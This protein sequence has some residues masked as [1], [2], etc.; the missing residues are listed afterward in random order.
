MLTQNYLYY[1]FKITEAAFL[2][3][4]GL[5]AL[6]MLIVAVVALSKLQRGT[7]LRTLSAGGSIVLAVILF[8][9]AFSNIVYE[10][11]EH[12][13]TLI[14]DLLPA[15]EPCGTGWTNFIPSGNGMGGS[16]CKAGCYRGNVLRKQMRMRGLPPMP[17]TRR[18]IQC[19]NR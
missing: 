5:L 6:A 17:E 10:F 13:E 2:S 8:S 19:W 18:E 7:W 15:G 1:V 14:S 16:P 12:P 11:D 4:L 3:A 9:V